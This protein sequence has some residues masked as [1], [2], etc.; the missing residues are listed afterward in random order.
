MTELENHHLA[1]PNKITDVGNDDQDMLKLFGERLLGNL[2][3]LI[4]NEPTAQ[5]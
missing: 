3:G 4:I 2:D 5:C 1:N